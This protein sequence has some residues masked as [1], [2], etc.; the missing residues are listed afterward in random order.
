VFNN[1]SQLQSIKIVRDV[2]TSET[3]GDEK[4]RVNITD[5]KCPECSGPVRKWTRHRC[6]ECKGK[7]GL[8]MKE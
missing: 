7:I 8:K 6:P 3:P 4:W 5:L 2:M 1:Y